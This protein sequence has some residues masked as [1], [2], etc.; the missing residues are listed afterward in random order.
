MY[1]SSSKNKRANAVTD[2]LTVLTVMFVFG[3]LSIVGYMVFDDL[4]AGVQSD[5]NLGST[6]KG[7]SSDLYDRY[8]ATLDGA[9]LTAFVLMVIFA[10]VSVFVI[11]TH[12]IYFILAVVLLIAVFVVGGF[13]ANAFNDIVTTPGISEYANEFTAT[14]FIMGNLIQVI[15]GVV[16]VMLVALF[17]KFRSL[18]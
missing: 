15:L 18:S 8:P 3:I 11:D 9:F 1:F 6:A 4:N 10:I 14:G 5:P 13:L 7:I 2:S 16:M 17:A 12:P